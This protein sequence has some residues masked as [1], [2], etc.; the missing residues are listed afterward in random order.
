MKTRT[1]KQHKALQKANSY[2]I[3]YARISAI[4]RRTGFSFN[5]EYSGKPY[6]CIVLRLAGYYVRSY[7]TP[8]AALRYLQRL[9]DRAI[10]KGISPEQIALPIF[11][12]LI[13]TN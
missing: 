12:R 11:N 10:A 5:W 6:K 3:I 8:L 9:I 13:K 4:C 1:A 7:K 2:R